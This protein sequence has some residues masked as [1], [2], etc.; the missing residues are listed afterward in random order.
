[1]EA[2][3]AGLALILACSVPG[4]SVRF[5]ADVARELPYSAWLSARAAPANM[6]ADAEAKTQKL[7]QFMTVPRRLN[8]PELPAGVH[9]C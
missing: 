8:L 1:M 9:R 6:K 7:V 2:R 5:G 4:P 3:T